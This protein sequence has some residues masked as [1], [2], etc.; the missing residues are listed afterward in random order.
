MTENQHRTELLQCL[1]KENELAI[2]NLKKVITNLPAE[3]TG[4]DIQI[5]ACQEDDGMLWIDIA[6]E[7]EDLHSLNNQIENFNDL[8]DVKHTEKGLS[9]DIPYV[10]A[11][12]VNYDVY[13]VVCETAI[14]WCKELWQ[15]IDASSVP[16]TIVITDDFGEFEPIKLI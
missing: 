11:D 16:V 6:L 5:A 10:D 9:K 4:I 3:T 15:N 7:G 12:D 8:F 14:L 13:I 1:R 2:T